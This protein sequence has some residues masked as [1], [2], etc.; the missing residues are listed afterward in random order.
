MAIFLSKNNVAPY[1]KLT[2][3][4]ITDAIEINASSGS[5]IV[6]YVSPIYLIVTNASYN[7][8]E[9]RVENENSSGTSLYISPVDGLGTP[10][11]W[12]KLMILNSLDATG[13]DV[14]IL[15]KYKWSVINNI[16]LLKRLNVS[17]N[18]N[19]YEV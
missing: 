5:N 19:I 3:F 13:S 6:E 17:G 2:D 11:H 1:E 7:N 15:F 12:G 4:K 18:I 10:T 14:K 9:I 8:I 16:F